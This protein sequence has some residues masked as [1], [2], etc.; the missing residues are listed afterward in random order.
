[1]IDPREQNPWTLSPLQTRSATL[2]TGDYSVAGLEN[3][4]AIEHKSLSDL[5]GCIGGERERFDREV[6][7]LLGY[8]VLALIVEASWADVERGDWRS[9]VKPSAVVGS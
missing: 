4:I 1:L 3:V 5:L 7:R 9:Q 8:P 6:V 2:P